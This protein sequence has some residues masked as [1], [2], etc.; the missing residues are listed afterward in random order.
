[1]MQENTV[2]TRRKFDAPEDRRKFLFIVV[3]TA[4]GKRTK[5]NKF[6]FKLTGSHSREHV[7]STDLQHWNSQEISP[8]HAS[9]Q[10][11]KLVR[12]S[13][14]VTCTHA[15]RVCD[16]TQIQRETTRIL[17]CCVV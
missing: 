15:A 3:W 2:R 8:I 16:N 10:H 13:S 4:V 6:K 11:V 9:L 1:M 5:Q 17:A 7:L 12:H 14:C